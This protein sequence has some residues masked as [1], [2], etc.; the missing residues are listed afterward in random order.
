MGYDV[1]SIEFKY[2]F[3]R[4]LRATVELYMEG[5]KGEQKPQVESQGEPSLGNDAQG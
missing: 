5:F 3:E 1:S 2:H 4:C